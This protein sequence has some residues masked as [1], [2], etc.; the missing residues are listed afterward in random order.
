[1]SELKI[2]EQA[3]DFELVDAGGTPFTLSALRGGRNAYLVLN[4]GF[5]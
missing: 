2:G 1:M 5:S 3:P 4:R